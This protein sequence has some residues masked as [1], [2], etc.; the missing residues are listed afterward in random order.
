MIRRPPRS[1]RFPYTTLFRSR[2]ARKGVLAGEVAMTLAV[3]GTLVQVEHFV[4]ILVAM[5][6]GGVVG[7]PLARVPLK[8]GRGYALTPDTPI[9]RMPPSAWKNINH[10]SAPRM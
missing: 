5:V 1:T 4:W 2:T 9:F 6:L 10:F 3:I 7:I 8:I